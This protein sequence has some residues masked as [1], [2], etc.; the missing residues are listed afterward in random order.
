MSE[1]KESDT[2]RQRKF[3]QQEFLRLKKMQQGELDAGPKPSELAGE[4]TFKDKIKNI[5]FHD[6]FAIA[7]IAILVIAISLLITQC[8]TKTKYD[9]TI[10]LFTHSITG[11]TNCYKMGE[12]LKPFCDDINGDGE[13]NINV[14]NCSI[15]VNDGN[16]EYNYTTRSKM[17]SILATDA[18]ALLFI[19]DDDS[20]EYLM[21]LSEKVSLF[22][23]EPIKFTKEFYDF[24]VDSNGFYDTPENLQISCRTLKD[25]A[26]EKNKN[27]DKY[28][29]NAQKILE[30]INKHIADIELP[31]TTNESN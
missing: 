16:N 23:G 14:I 27:A 2:L 24:C 11:D 18:S 31:E 10:V 7:V 1:K 17:Q 3:A 19:T 30:K 29:E 26:I 12:Y 21:G 13:K 15:N 4:L 5:W 9:A 6:K 8:A 25:T 28:Y 20:Y 22:E